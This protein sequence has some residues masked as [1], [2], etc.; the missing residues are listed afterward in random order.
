MEHLKNKV[1]KEEMVQRSCNLVSATDNDHEN[2]HKAINIA[3]PDT[4]S[5]EY[6]IE[7]LHSKAR[8]KPIL[9][10]FKR[11]HAKELK[12]HGFQFVWCKGGQVYVRK[13]DGQPHV[14]IKVVD[15]VELLI[16]GVNI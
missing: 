6:S 11:K 5:D 3:D 14:R 1:D 15:H 16:R 12:K 10:K 4:S 8:R 7:V 13:N 9:V 2:V